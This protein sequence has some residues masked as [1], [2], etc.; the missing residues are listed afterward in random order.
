MKNILQVL[1]QIVLVSVVD[2]IFQLYIRKKLRLVTTRI[3]DNTSLIESTAAL[4]AEKAT[5]NTKIDALEKKQT[6]QNTEILGQIQVIQNTI[7]TRYV[8]RN[9]RTNE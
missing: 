7:G 5:Q 1:I 3:D 9:T 6:T 2:V 4:Q 8:I